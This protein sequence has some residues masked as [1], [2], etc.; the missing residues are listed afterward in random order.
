MKKKFN[1]KRTA[2][3]LAL[4]LVATNSLSLLAPPISS[5]SLGIG[6]LAAKGLNYSVIAKADV[7]EDATI[8]LDSSCLNINGTNIE[9]RDRDAIESKLRNTSGNIIKVKFDPSL[10]INGIS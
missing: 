8:T 3:I 1:T 6:A 10:N 4:A 9:Y 2:G 7:R 5:G